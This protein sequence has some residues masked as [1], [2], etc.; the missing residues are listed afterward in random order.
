MAKRSDGFLFSLFSWNVIVRR[1]A[2]RQS[3]KLQING[4][5]TR[6]T[7]VVPMILDIRHSDPVGSV[8]RSPPRS[9]VRNPKVDPNRN[10]PLIRVHTAG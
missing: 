9:V 1:S 8:P 6:G 4:E 5:G 2:A 10:A 7:G 3:S